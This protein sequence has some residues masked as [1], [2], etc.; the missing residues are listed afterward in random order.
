MN[1]YNNDKILVTTV[2]LS[3]LGVL[4]KVNSEDNYFSWLVS[5]HHSLHSVSVETDFVIALQLGSAQK[6]RTTFSTNQK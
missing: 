3:S 6:S 4:T 1:P 5:L 2:L